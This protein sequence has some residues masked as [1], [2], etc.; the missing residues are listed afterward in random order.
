MY[1]GMLLAQSGRQLTVVA[2][3]IQVFRMTDSTFAV[4]LLG[5]AQ[6]IPL[7][8][9]SFVGGALVDAVDR[10]LLLILAEVLMALTS[11]GLWWNS[12]L[13]EPLLWPL[14]TLTAISGGVGAIHNPARQAMLPGLVGRDLFSAA[15]ALNQTQTNVAK[16]VVPAV[17]GLLIAYAGLPTTYA[18]Q[19]L[20]LVGSVGLLS[21]V[22]RVEIEGGRRAFS[23][24]S[25]REGF[26][27]LGS[28]QL[29]QAAM[30]IDLGAMVFGMPTALFP[31]FGE[32][33]LGGDDV[34]VGLL[35]AAPG[36]GA[37][38]A[39]V[40][41]G[42]IPGVH[43]QGRAVVIA[44]SCWGIGIAVFG[45]STSL[46]LALAMLAFAGAADVVSAIFRQSI[47]QLSV[48]DTLRG[49][50]DVDPRRR[51]GRRTPAG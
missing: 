13:D 4:G 17:G 19:T 44:V 8:L 20:L 42:W 25:I 6:L 35:F 10:R 48:P 38:I 32:D 27:F 45:L 24:T 41:S 50:R 36:A 51:V 47:I 2:V 15:L 46:P 39:A 12:S 37:M 43:R 34:T 3:P 31:A 23:M 9:V 1:A 28:R 21:R 7:L 49:A 11:L 33:V 26:S 16:M 30:L 14:Y 29:I 5:L 40:T 22:E 18:I